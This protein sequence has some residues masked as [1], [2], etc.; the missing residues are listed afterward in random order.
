MS[1]DVSSE[2]SRQD[3]G[4]PAPGQTVDYARRGSGPGFQAA[5]DV[6]GGEGGTDQPEPWTP[7]G[8]A[9]IRDQQIRILSDWAT[10]HDLWISVEDLGP[11]NS[12]R[13]EH[14]VFGTRMAGKHAFKA[15]KGAKFGFWPSVAK[16]VVSTRLDEHLVM[17][18]ATPAQY[19]SRLILLDSLQPDINR[20]QG[21]SQLEG[22]FSIIT[23]QFWYAARNATWVEI[24]RWL[25]DLGFRPVRDDIYDDPTRWYHAEQNLALFDV[26]ESNI[27]YSDGQLVPINIIPIRPHGLLRE[28][29]E[30]F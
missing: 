9:V 27:L 15:T 30:R 28:T 14:A 7:A 18:P 1:G 21:F 22:H 13:M 12:G 17:R 5:L 6:L 16:D 29:L 25:R 19:F 26:G 2:T 3:P 20:L 10:S 8:F 23:S 4:S 24:S 11:R